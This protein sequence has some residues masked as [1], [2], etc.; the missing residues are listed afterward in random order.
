MNLF[1]SCGSFWWLIADSWQ[2]CLVSTVL[3]TTHMYSF[4]SQFLMF[5]YPGY[6]WHTLV[7]MLQSYLVVYTL[8][9]ACFFWHDTINDKPV[10]F[11][12]S[13]K[14]VALLS[15]GCYHAST[16]GIISMIDIL[17]RKV[18][19]IIITKQTHFIHKTKFLQSMLNLL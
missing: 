18:L 13:F 17:T 1:T 7:V 12:S 15:H 3:N 8:S 6:C 2:H 9:F 10:F 14:T 4:W 19:I 5:L 16:G 11:R